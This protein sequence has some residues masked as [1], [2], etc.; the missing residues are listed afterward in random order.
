MARPTDG[1]EEA[2]GGLGYEAPEPTT[3]N[4]HK[5]AA[6]PN[7]PT[8]DELKDRFTERFPDYAYGLAEWRAYAN[9]AWR[10][11]PEL[12]VKRQIADILEDAKPE[13][14][15]PTAG[16]L[17]SVTELARVGLH[18]PDEKWDADLDILVCQNGTLS[19]SSRELCEH[20]REDFATS[21]V[22]YAYD[23][24]TA[25]PIWRYFL[26]STMPDAAEFLQEFAG[27]ALTT[28]T[29]L[30]TALWLAGPRGSGKST[31][32][33]GFQAMLG[34][35]AGLLGLAD[36]ER[37]RFALSNLPGK[38]L[39]VATEQPSNYISSTHTLN[40]IISGEPV[41]VERKYRDA[42]TII[43][44]A[45]VAWAMND[46]PR[47][48]EANSG[49]FRRVKVVKFPELREEHRDPKIKQFIAT[50][51]AG[52]L[53]WAL[54]G[55]ERLKERGYFDIPQSVQT[56]T[57]HFQET[58]DV[59]ALFVEEMCERDKEAR[60]Q[61]SQLY[62]EYKYWC[63]ENGHRPLSSTRVAAEWERLGFEKR[64]PGGLSY[65][66][67]LRLRLPNE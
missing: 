41:Q 31:L 38:T 1:F 12:S 29:S 3:T 65:Y 58:N 19:I 18:V 63:D 59:A 37:N 16:L 20:R 24:K 7:A 55:L 64:R 53:N 49:L 14:I 5:L 28:D 33:T 4:G 9:G 10:P 32:L 44:R 40:A 62:R 67:G 39:V 60:I 2:Y 27:Y 52:I 66:Y 47:V 43:P 22:P 17:A 57:E 8:H 61:A 45:K 56:A 6:K 15:R 34:A 23:Q 30:E 51:G 48:G 11:I 13:G 54:E 35:K 26:N 46:L 21:A 25:A 50:E 42:Y 36:I